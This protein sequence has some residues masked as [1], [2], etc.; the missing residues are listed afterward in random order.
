M[1]FCGQDVPPSHGCGALRGG[2]LLR[3]VGAQPGGGRGQRPPGVPAGAQ[4][5]RGPGRHHRGRRQR[6]DR[7]CQNQWET[8]QNEASFLPHLQVISF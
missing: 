3:E 6:A 7:R 1:L 5:R 8:S 2:A 4:P